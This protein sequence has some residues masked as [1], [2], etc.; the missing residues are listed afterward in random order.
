M[1]TTSDSNKRAV[2]PR[3]AASL[4]LHRR[5]ADDIEVLMGRRSESAR[6]MP[7]VY[8]FPGGAV[9]ASDRRVQ[10]A[11]ALPRGLH[12]LLKVGG[13]AERARAMG[14]TAVRETYE[15]TGLMVAAPGDPALTDHALWCDWHEQRMAPNLACLDLMARA[16]T[17]PTRPIRFH[18]RFFLTDAEHAQGRIRG[19]GELE[20]IGWIALKR[21]HELP[22]ANI[23]GFLLEHIA[24]VLSGEAGN[25]R[26]LFSFHGGRRRIRW[27]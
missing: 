23:Q 13:N 9:D 16:I 22:L 2:R 19:D 10:P 15:E 21:T 3:D 24:R 20:D 6:F 11:T 17:P 7:G 26:P 27:E 14:I 8:V 5:A 12:P 18:A 4:V 1:T 25:R